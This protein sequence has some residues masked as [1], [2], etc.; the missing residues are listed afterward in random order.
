MS[1][2][3]LQEAR[4]IVALHH[5]LAN[6]GVQVPRSLLDS[7]T[8]ELCM[9]YL[10]DITAYQYVTHETACES[11]DNQWSIIFNTN[12]SPLLPLIHLHATPIDGLP[13]SPTKPWQSIC[14]RLLQ[15]HDAGDTD[16]EHLAMLSNRLNSF[17]LTLR[18]HEALTDSLH[19]DKHHL[20]H[21]DFHF[22][23]VLLDLQTPCTWLIDLDDVGIGHREQDIGNLLA[24]IMTS[25]E[26]LRDSPVACHDRLKMLVIMSL[27][28]LGSKRLN[29]QRLAF[30]TALSLL[31]RA[32]KFVTDDRYEVHRKCLNE[33]Y[34]T[35]ME[36]LIDRHASPS[37]IT[38]F[39]PE[40]AKD[41]IANG[42]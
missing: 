27:K 16:D 9:P 31:R 35:F 4:R 2:F 17:Y 6:A 22:R 23:Q 41:T 24:H 14:N 34:L 7:S 42:F 13:V 15:I 36:T 18:Q 32:L 25:K 3:S 39:T 26:F 29:Q 40:P 30:Y 12:I 1:R 20:V 33:N 37:L 28:K 38:R 19:R 11:D 5:A 10:S 8:R 21:G